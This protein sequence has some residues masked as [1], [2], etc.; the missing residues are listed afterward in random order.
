MLV[1]SIVVYFELY[2]TQILF[3]SILNANECR[4][5]IPSSHLCWQKLTTFYKYKDDLF[6]AF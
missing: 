4:E 1:N 2:I 6:F 3:F 5:C